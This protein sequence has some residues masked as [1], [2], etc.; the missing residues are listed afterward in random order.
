MG[1]QLDRETIA[2]G[3]AF[4]EANASAYLGTF[5]SNAEA[6]CR[7]EKRP[8]VTGSVSTGEKELRIWAA[9]F[10]TRLQRISEAYLQKT[11]VV[12]NRA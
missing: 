2:P 9:L 7:I 1:V 4:L 11:G 12:G 6:L 8:M 3:I 5:S 10:L